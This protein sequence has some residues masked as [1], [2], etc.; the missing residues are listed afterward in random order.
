[1]TDVAA[2]LHG[3]G[4]DRYEAA[5]RDNEIRPDVLPSL[6]AEDLKEIGV[7]AVGDRRRLLDAI[8]A[9]RC[10]ALSVALAAEPPPG[11]AGADHGAEGRG[12]ERRQLTVLFCDLAG[13]TAL[14]A[15]LDPEDLREVMAAYHRTVAEAVRRQGGYV[16]KLL[17]DGVLAYFGWPRAH[18]DDAERAVRS[19]LAAAEAVAGLET[20]AGPLSARV[21]I[22]T[23][24]VVVGEVMGEGEARERGV[25]GETPNRAARLQAIAEPGAVVAD[26]ATRR[27]TGALFAWADLGAAALKGVPEPARVWR[28]LGESQVESRFEA[29]RSGAHAAPLIGREEELELLLRRWR[30]ARSGEG[31]VVLLRGEAGIGKSRLAAAMQEALTREGHEE[32]VLH[33]SPQH[34]NSALRPVVA[35]LERAAGLAPDGAPED[36]LL[37]LEALLL[38]LDPPPEDVALLADLLSV[39]TLGRWPALDLSPQRRRER[40]LE[41]LVRRVSALAARRPVLAVVEDAHWLDP[42]TR[43]LLDLLVAKAPETPLL[44]VVT[45]RPEFHAGAWIGMPQVSPLQLGRLGRAEHVELLRWVAGGKALPAAVEAEILARTDGVPLFVEEVTRAVLEGGLLREE[46]ERW[47]LDGPLPRLTVPATLQA[48]LVAR[49]DRLSSVRQVAQ[50]G[51]VLGRE[52]AHDL[53]AAVAGL[54]EARLCEAL[55]VLAAE[56][57]VRRRGEPPDATYVFRHVLIQDAARATLLRE[58]RRVLHRRAAEAIGRL[59]PRVAE[60][61]P[62]VLAR[63]CVEAGM[64]AEAIGYSVR[65]AEL[66]LAR[67]AIPEAIGHLSIGLGEVE[68]LADPAKRDRGE[69]TL[70][71]GLG[72]ALIIKGGSGAAETGAAF[73]RAHE[74]ARS[75]DDAEQTFHSLYGLCHFHFNRL[76]L[77]DGLRYSRE[78][79]ALGERTGA[80]QPLLTG[81]RGVG[82]AMLLAGGFL[83]ARD[84]FE[85]VLSIYE[86]DRDARLA[87]QTSFD[88]KVIALINLALIEL[89]LGRPERGLARARASL[90]G[91]AQLGHPATL[92]VALRRDAI[93]HLLRREPRTASA[94]AD[95]LL[96][97][98]SSTA[99][100]LGRWRGGSCVSAPP[101]GKHSTRGPSL[102]PLKPNWGC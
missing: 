81:H 69:L 7:A 27:L 55:G 65:A 50:A 92:A 87:E 97:L 10:A 63:H 86:P 68:R 18:E 33:C 78:M 16:A 4:L 100:A 62:E 47:A 64:S 93:F 79:L 71:L 49:F 82:T 80:R 90:E 24:L 21:G 77:A 25:V 12:A 52:F 89:L 28:A 48:S 66:A 15:R 22:A 32:L 72:R 40:L 83:A 75:L 11:D 2:W 99:S 41:A 44:L 9:L 73:R 38:P 76:E 26:A 35:G 13:S 70:R 85:A 102:A 54:S 94:V 61:E 30:R 91:A 1:M 53:V 60:R 17:G 67:S 57:L 42:T 3:L 29:L 31:Q 14:A 6:T 45:H 95:R 98:A 39:P 36:R 59:R 23:G 5:F 101:S 58:R 8:A 88:P 43:E 74:L 19:G 37:K 56:D 51:A 96:T 34:T 20:T 84:A 46:A